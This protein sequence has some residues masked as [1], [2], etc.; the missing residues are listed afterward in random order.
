VPTA[1]SAHPDPFLAS[2]PRSWVEA[3][4]TVSRWSEMPQG[5]HFAAMEVPDLFVSALRSWIRD[6]A[7]DRHLSGTACIVV[8][9]FGLL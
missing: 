5:G 4:Y 3:G 1:F 8:L 6:Q 2:T 7:S 9:R